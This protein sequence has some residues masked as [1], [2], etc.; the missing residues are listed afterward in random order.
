MPGCGQIHVAVL[1]RTR[2]HRNQYASR[3]RMFQRVFF[4]KRSLARGAWERD[5]TDCLSRR[6]LS[7]HGSGFVDQEDGLDDAT[8]RK[9][10]VC[11]EIR[12]DG[13]KDTPVLRCPGGQ[14]IKPRGF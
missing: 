13:A 2:V 6:A 10:K 8:R 5:R 14:T 12:I 7:E 4:E 3:V 1:F 9:R 11:G